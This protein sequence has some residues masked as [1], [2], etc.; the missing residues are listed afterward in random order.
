MSAAGPDE[1]SRDGPPTS[2][3]TNV[4]GLVVLVVEDEFLLACSL[5]E[6]LRSFGCTVVGPFNNLA[7]AT[8]RSRVEQFEIALLDMN[9]NGTMAYALADELQA[10]NIPL[11]ILSGYGSSDLPERFR[12]LP[13]M[14]KPYDPRVLIQTIRKAAAR[15]R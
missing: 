13:R 6:D 4:D 10:R 3:T 5:E 14:L 2:D 1:N 7:L 12:S 9:L 15:A 11:V 8:D